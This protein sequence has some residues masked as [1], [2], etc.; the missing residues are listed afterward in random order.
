MFLPVEKKPQWQNPPILTMLLILISIG[1]F[2]TWQNNDTER[3]RT[4][5]QYYF[6]S[7][8]ADIEIPAYLE[9]LKNPQH[10]SYLNFKERL[11]QNPQRAKKQLLQ[12]LIVDGLF[13]RQL[14]NE[15][16]I[17]PQYTRFNEWQKKHVEFQRLLNRVVKYRFG[18][19]PYQPSLATLVIHNFL[20]DSVGHI[21][22]NMVFLFMF[23]FVIELAIGRIAYLFLFLASGMASAM[24]LTLF[25]ANAAYWTI[26]ASGAIAGLVGFYTILY[27]TRKIRFFYT[28][29]VYFNYIKAPAIIILPLWLGYEIINQLVFHAHISNLSHIGG[30][31]TGI[32]LGLIYKSYPGL[33]HQQVIEGNHAELAFQAKLQ[34]VRRLIANLEFNP[35]H[36]LL[37][38]L[39]IEQPNNFEVIQQLYHLEKI[40]PDTDQYHVFAH[41]LLKLSI[42]SSGYEEFVH[43]IY[44]E[45]SETAKPQPKFTTELLYYLAKL[46]SR[47][48]YLEDAETL[49][50][51]LLSHDT[52]KDELPEVL[53]ML[54]AA[55]KRAANEDKYN[56]YKNRLISDFPNSKQAQI[57]QA[58]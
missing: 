27:G 4:A 24:T 22:L 39:L 53:L 17:T 49:C 46:F 3:E 37:N 9:Y 1:C 5:Y 54:L 11:K 50:Q 36:R 23:G 43:N 35:A 6:D 55:L 30:L 58:L 40:H 47:K 48:D 21:V 2:F 41:Q 31:L 13:L 52:D 8:L 12:S 25:D 32:L 7:G 51:Y 10:A 34:Q 45:Y 28:A 57:V 29:F 14:S 16:I 44:K 26:G 15:Q 42:E 33:I 38:Q 56:Y 19:K 18:F 20:H